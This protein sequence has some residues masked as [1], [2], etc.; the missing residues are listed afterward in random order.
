[1]AGIF[2]TEAALQ[3][4]E[5]ME[6]SLVNLMAQRP[7]QDITVTDI[8]RGANIPRR[9][10][11][12]YFGS[13][14]DVLQSMIET[15]MEQCFMEATFDMHLGKEQLE[16]NFSKTFRSWDGANREKLDVLIRNGLESRL[17]AWAFQWVRKERIGI[18]QKSNLDPK[19]KEIGL[20]VGTTSYFSLLFYWSRGGYRESAEQ[21]AKYAVWAMSHP[22]SDL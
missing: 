8:C 20:M 21:M 17:I 18:V 12:H 1:M 10:F 9:T 6:N 16:D 7:Y 3:K 19:L 4:K 14:E 22:F 11:Y 2:H 15:L 13:K 5:Q